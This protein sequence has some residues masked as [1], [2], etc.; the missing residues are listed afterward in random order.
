MPSRVSI[1]TPRP[2]Q[3]SVSVSRGPCVLTTAGFLAWS[4]SKGRKCQCTQ[5]MARPATCKRCQH[6]KKVS[7]HEEGVPLSLAQATYRSRSDVHARLCQEIIVFE[8]VFE[9]LMHLA[10]KCLAAKGFGER[11]CVK[12]D[13]GMDSFHRLRAHAIRLCKW[14]APSARLYHGAGTDSGSCVANNQ[15]P[16]VASGRRQ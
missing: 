13:C 11:W 8:L 10:D 16:C 1:S 7:E 14:S 6:T 15:V 2:H 9:F 3:A 5:R 4:C 12:H